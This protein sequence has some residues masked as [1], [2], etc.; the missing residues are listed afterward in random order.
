MSRVKTGIKVAI[1]TL[2]ASLTDMHHD[3]TITTDKQTNRNKN[4]QRG[5]LPVNVNVRDDVV[6]S[7]VDANPH[8]NKLAVKWIGL[9]RVISAD[10]NSFEIEHLLT[11]ATRTV[12]A[13]RLNRY[14]D[15]SLN[16]NEEKLEH[17]AHQD[18]YLTVEAFCNG[19]T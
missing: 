7:R 13:S 16:V 18:V 3:I 19:L 14:A 5:E 8:V 6:W 12:H 2:R 15:N 9:Y 1:E 17:L 11:G 4:S 10:V